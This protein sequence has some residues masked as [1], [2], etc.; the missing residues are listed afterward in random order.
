MSFPLTVSYPQE[1]D[2]P[3]ECLYLVAMYFAR[4]GPG[5]FIYLQE[6]LYPLVIFFRLITDVQNL[7]VAGNDKLR[8]HFRNEIEREVSV[9]TCEG[10]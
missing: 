1:P 10:S 5:R 4:L 2:R 3:E 8:V 7:P 6:S 9:V